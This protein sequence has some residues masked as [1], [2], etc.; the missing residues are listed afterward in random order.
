MTLSAVSPSRIHTHAGG[1]T[2]DFIAL[3]CL[4]HCGAADYR[5][6]GEGGEHQ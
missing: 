5:L 2:D 1:N 6:A 3:G 4:A